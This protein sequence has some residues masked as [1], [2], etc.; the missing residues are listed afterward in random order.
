VWHLTILLLYVFFPLR[1][2]V[3]VILGDL[4]IVKVILILVLTT[5]I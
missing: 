1:H 4:L 2:L 5:V 3:Q